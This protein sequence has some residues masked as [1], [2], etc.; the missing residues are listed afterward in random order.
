MFKGYDRAKYDLQDPSAYHAIKRDQA[1]HE[2]AL[3]TVARYLNTPVSRQGR[4]Q[5][6]QIVLPP[7]QQAELTT[8]MPADLQA[9]ER[10]ELG[11]LTMLDPIVAAA[12]RE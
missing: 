12:L 11:Q 8:Q 6:P 7:A 5:I 3:R 10:T 1:L 4:T 2:D 9:Y